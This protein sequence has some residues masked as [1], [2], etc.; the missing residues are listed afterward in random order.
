MP[1][2]LDPVITIDPTGGAFDGND[3]RTKTAFQNGPT[4][5]AFARLRTTMPETLFDSK[6]IFDNQPAFWD[7]SEVSGSGTT[8]THSQDTASSTLGVAATTAGKRVRQTFMRM[9]YQPGKSQLILCTGTLDKSGGGTGI[10]RGFGYYDDENGIFLQDNEGTLQI[11]KRSHVT[12]STV[13]IEEDQDDWN[14]DTMDGNGGSGVTLDMSKTQI[15][16][17]D[18]SWL[19]SGRVRVGFVIGG[20]IIYVHEFKHS[21]AVSGVYMSTP[22]LP[23]RYEIENDGT[24]AA[25]TLEH[26]CC[27]VISEGGLE[28]L[29]VLRSRNTGTTEIHANTIGICYALV[30][31]RL[32]SV[33]TSATIKFTRGTVLATT[34]DNFYWEVRGNPTVAGTFT[35]A[36]LSGS[37]AQTAIG[38]ASNPSTSTVTGGIILD[39]GYGNGNNMIETNVVNAQHMG[40]AIDGTLDEIVLCVTPLTTNLNVHGSLSWREFI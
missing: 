30:G 22:N 39:S 24:G 6:Q 19:G 25:S 7:D 37:C 40:A 5:D 13:D 26:I 28:D 34:N 4:L 23:M 12:G 2:N 27:T 38:E 10:T 32:K 20:D 16:L 1:G 33:H 17:I 3:L 8:S 11:V 31:I 21:N 36:D 15:L 14:I 18:F 29:G 35:F 9:N